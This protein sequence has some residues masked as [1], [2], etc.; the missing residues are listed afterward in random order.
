MIV[1]A[2]V[3]SYLVVKLHLYHCIS[4][5]YVEMPRTK[6]IIFLAPKSI[7]ENTQLGFRVRVSKLEMESEGNSDAHLVT[8]A[9]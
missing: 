7:Q 9:S 2:T 8:I 4:V 5:W 3:S 1:I 6:K